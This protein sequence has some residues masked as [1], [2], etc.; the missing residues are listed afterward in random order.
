LPLA[1]F[2]PLYVVGRS[3]EESLRV[4][5]LARELGLTVGGTSKIV[6]RIVGAGFLR[7]DPDA[8]D[9]RA[10]RVV[11]TNTG[12]HSLTAASKTYEVEMSAVLDASLS[13]DQQQC[14]HNLVRRLRA[15]FDDIKP[16]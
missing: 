14:M 11:L 6:D 16:I 10:S 4:G 5:E 8:A 13:T 12:R 15:G 1:L 2:W 9:R 3:S 7:R